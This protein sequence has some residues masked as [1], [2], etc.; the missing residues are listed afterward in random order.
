MIQAG[1]TGVEMGQGMEPGKSWVYAITNKKT[2]IYP[3]ITFQS[4]VGA[5][6]WAGSW[7]EYPELWETSQ[8][9]SGMLGGSS[10]RP[11]SAGVGGGSAASTS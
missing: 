9:S 1:P 4:R 8:L 6:G 5:P 2:S 3:K 11:T 7:E 10:S